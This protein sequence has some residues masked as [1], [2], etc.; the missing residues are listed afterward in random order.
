MSA[1]DDARLDAL[2]RRARDAAR[3]LLDDL[4]SRDADTPVTDPPVAPEPAVIRLDGADGHRTR[5]RLL[6][7]AAVVVLA[8]AGGAVAVLTRDDGGA[9]V[10]SRGRLDYLLPGWLPAGF[11]PTQAIDLAA[12]AVPGGF[13]GD[14]A[15]YGNPDAADPWSGTLVVIHLVAD[16]EGLGGPLS[17]GDPITVDGDDAVLRETEGPE[18]EGPGRGWEVE[19]QVDDG[20]LIVG[21]ALTRDEILAAAE[22]ATIEP[23]VDASA[24]PDGY[25]ELARGP[26]AAATPTLFDNAMY[27]SGLAVTY[28]DGSGGD[29]GATIDS[30]PSGDDGGTMLAVV[31]R[32]GPASA[33]DLLRAS[34]PDSGSITVRG[35]H[36]AI[37]R[38]DFNE[39]NG[40]VAVQWAEPEGQLVTVVGFGVA[41]DA[42]LRVAEELRLATAGEI[43][44]LL[45]EHGGA[46]GGEF[47]DAP[48]GHVVVAEGETPSGRWRVTADATRPPGME[49]LTIERM[50]D[51]TSSSGTASGTGGD[52]TAGPPALAL[53]TDT[54]D[55]VTVVYGLVP[56]GTASV[57]YEAPGVVGGLDL[58]EVDG[59]DVGVVAVDIT[60]ELPADIAADVVDAVTVIARGAD[61]RELGRQ[62]IAVEHDPFPPDGEQPADVVEECTVLPDGSEQCSYSESGETTDTIR[63]DG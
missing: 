3:T 5:R 43:D 62:T 9:D 27:R 31:Q 15:V 51:S 42:L 7:A 37:G 49:A 41:E 26:V 34:F 60:E 59:W 55:G 44:A 22:A 57:T 45:D 21:G 35:R 2:D 8:L 4:A 38:G 23:A 29:D 48:D 30:D 16:E 28:S 19:R 40:M 6:A 36:A 53:S 63:A 39:S 33:V 61:G 50:S 58:H 14:I 10:T 47:D 52:G 32:P 20:R 1:T 25:E 12:E 54:E 17:D 13:G 18:S 46:A 56:E 11:E 24:L